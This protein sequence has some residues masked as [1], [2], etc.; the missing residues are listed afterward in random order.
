MILKNIHWPCFPHFTM[1]RQNHHELSCEFTN[2]HLGTTVLAL[3]L[4]PDCF[5]WKTRRPVPSR[6]FLTLLWD[7]YFIFIYLF[8]LFWAALSACGSS[9][10]RGQIRTAAAGLCHS[11]N[12]A[13]ATTDWGTT[14]QGNTRSLT[15]WTRPGIES[16]SSWII[17]GFISAA[18]LWA[19]QDCYFKH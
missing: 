2:K 18:P 6:L 14:A 4:F 16:A 8:L 1:V 7:C 19:L 10:A 9:H 5:K 15:H 12:K 3:V 13:R 17:V 11:H